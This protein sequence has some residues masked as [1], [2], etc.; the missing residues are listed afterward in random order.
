MIFDTH[1]H[2]DDSRYD[3]DRDEVIVNCRN[4]NVGLIL[5]V[6]AE[7]RGCYDSIEL[8]KKY[9]FVYAAVGIHPHDTEEMDDTV[10]RTLKELTKYE[11]VVAIGEIGLDYYYD[12]SP[13]EIQ[14]YWFGKQLQLAAS[15][16]LPVL[17]HDRDAHEDIMTHLQ[18]YVRLTKEPKGVIHCYS[19]SAEMAKQLVRMGFHIAFGGALTFKNAKKSHEAIKAVPLDRLL[20]ETDSP[21]LS[22]EPYRGKRNDSSN[23]KYVAQKAGELLGLSGEEVEE[24]T[25]RNGRNL[26]KI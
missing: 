12:H 1:T 24:L 6:G 8:A 13:R 19:G 17:I 4:R 18:E 15:L 2:F 5:N 3:D 10:I 11:K 21:Y 23:I 14:K 26:F 16:D 7:L 22:P 20:L 9:N 25:Y